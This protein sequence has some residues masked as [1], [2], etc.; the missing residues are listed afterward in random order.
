MINSAGAQSKRLLDRIALPLA[1]IMPDLLRQRKWIF[2]TVPLPA[3]P[4]VHAS[5]LFVPCLRWPLL[6]H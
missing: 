2:Q 1:I 4:I 3:I 5:G 6:A